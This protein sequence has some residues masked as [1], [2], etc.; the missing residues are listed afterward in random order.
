MITKDPFLVRKKN[1]VRLCVWSNYRKIFFSFRQL[2]EQ[3]TFSDNLVWLV[4]HTFQVVSTLNRVQP[5][6]LLFTFYWHRQHF[7]QRN[8]KFSFCLFRKS[9]IQFMCHR[10][11]FNTNQPTSSLKIFHY[12]VYFFLFSLSF[13]FFSSFERDSSVKV[14]KGVVQFQDCLRKKKKLKIFLFIK[15]KPSHSVCQFPGDKKDA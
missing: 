3:A 4:F 12:R 6:F 9:C 15:Q 13:R 14:W 11:F 8:L 5:C 1:F 2:Q 10:F 7:D